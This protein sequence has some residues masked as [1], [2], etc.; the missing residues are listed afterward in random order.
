M[1]RS[2][3]PWAARTG[4]PDRADRCRARCRAGNGTI[5]AN[6]VYVEGVTDTCAASELALKLHDG[7]KRACAAARN[8]QRR[9]A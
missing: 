3:T 7:M 4:Y 9:A 1:P 2:L 8:R 5:L 6:R